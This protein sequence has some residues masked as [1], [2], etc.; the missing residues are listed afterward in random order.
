MSRVEQL[1]E[2]YL[3][4]KCSM[5]STVGPNGPSKVFRYFL[6][7]KNVGSVQRVHS[8]SISNLNPAHN[9]TLI[10]TDNW[11]ECRISVIA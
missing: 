9:L 7:I 3:T 8:Y 4:Y 2:T 5:Y 10:Q 6:K 1:V 11:G